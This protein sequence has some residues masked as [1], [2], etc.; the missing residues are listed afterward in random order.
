[1]SLLFLLAVARRASLQG[2]TIERRRYLV[3]VESQA[4]V[5]PA[6]AI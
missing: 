3:E 6:C 2:I 1:M 4:E 5:S